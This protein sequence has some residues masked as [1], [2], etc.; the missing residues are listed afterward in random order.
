[1]SACRGFSSSEIS[2][3]LSESHCELGG[4]ELND[5]LTGVHSIVFRNG[6]IRDITAYFCD[7]RDDPAID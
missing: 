1:V 4:V 5:D 6:D 7:D 2:F 3:C